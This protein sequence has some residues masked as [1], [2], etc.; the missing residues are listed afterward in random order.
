[1]SGLGRE[2]SLACALGVVMFRRVSV[3]PLGVWDLWGGRALCRAAKCCVSACFL[4]GVVMLLVLPV[5]CICEASSYHCPVGA[6]YV[7]I[8]L[9]PL[10]CRICAVIHPGARSA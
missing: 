8:M 10:L 5:I 4:V 7:V 3:W 6:H 1:L 9:L 2:N